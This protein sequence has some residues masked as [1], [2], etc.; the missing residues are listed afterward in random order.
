MSCFFCVCSCNPRES[1]LHNKPRKLLK[2]KIGNISRHILTVIFTLFYAYA[3]YASYAIYHML[4]YGVC[5]ICYAIS[6]PI[7][8]YLALCWSPKTETVEWLV[9]FLSLHSRAII[10]PSLWWNLL[11]YTYI[12]AVDY[13]FGVIRRYFLFQLGCATRS[14]HAWSMQHCILPSPFYKSHWRETSAQCSD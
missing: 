5:Y 6:C 9:Y 4:C 13:V 3:S 1:L 2:L 10:A 12:I 7:A 14:Y 11:L 8:F